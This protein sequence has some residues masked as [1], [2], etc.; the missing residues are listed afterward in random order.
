MTEVAGG[1]EHLPYDTH[2]STTQRPLRGCQLRMYVDVV[3]AY[4]CEDVFFVGLFVVKKLGGALCAIVLSPACMPEG[5][6]WWSTTSRHG[7]LLDLVGLRGLEHS[8]RW[9]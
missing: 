7:D 6:K 2:V 1:L 5:A 9:V 4:R 3:D 8:P